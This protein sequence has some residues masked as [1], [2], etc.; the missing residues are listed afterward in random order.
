LSLDLVG[1]G[2]L[3][4]LTGIGGEAWLDAPHNASDAFRI[5]IAA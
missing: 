5:E 3:T 2:R 4:L 1:K